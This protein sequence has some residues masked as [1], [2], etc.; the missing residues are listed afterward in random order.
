MCLS[1]VPSEAR[2]SVVESDSGDARVSGAAGEEDEGP[3]VSGG[4]FH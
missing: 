2:D 3:R 4:W 1:L